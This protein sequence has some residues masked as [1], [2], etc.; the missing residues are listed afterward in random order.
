MSYRDWE[1]A[2]GS[3]IAARARPLKLERG[4]LLVK[5][6]SATWSQELALLGDTIAAQLRSRGFRVHSL[7]FR[8]GRVDPPDRPPWRDEVRTEPP[9]VPLPLELKQQ[10][11]QVDDQDLRAAIARAASRNLG[12]QMLNAAE[13]RRAEARRKVRELPGMAPR[14]AWPGRPD[15][16]E[17]APA[18][19]PRRPPTEPLEVPTSAPPAARVPRS[20]A[21]ESARPARKKAPDAAIRRDKP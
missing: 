13:A 21:P 2:V 17:I 11:N 9:E 5:A 12:W 14:E 7:R 20:V 4:V 16:Q 10:L 15:A 1:A 3:R 8:V 6:A 19:P 18:G